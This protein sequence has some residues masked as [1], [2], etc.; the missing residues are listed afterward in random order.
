[1]RRTA[2]LRTPA[3]DWFRPRAALL[4]PG[5][6]SLLLAG[7]GCGEEDG[8]AAE[9]ATEAADSADVRPVVATAAIVPGSLTDVLE[10]SGRL[11]PRAEVMISSE[12]GG[13]VEEVRFDKGDRVVTGALLARVG[14]DLLRSALAEAEAELEGAQLDYTQA[15]LLVE[16]EASPRQ[17]FLGAEVNVKRFEARV[18][19]ARLRLARSEIAAPAAGVIVQRDIEPGEVLGPGSPVA[20][21]HDTSVLRATIGIP[22]TDIAFFSVGSPAE[23]AMDAYPDRSFEGRISYIAPSATRPGRNFQAEVEVANPD[24]VLRSGLIV[25]T[26]LQRRVFEDAVVVA[27][28]VLVERDGILHAFV[29]EDGTADL[30]AVTIG[31]DEG[32][33]VVITD[34]LAIGE[35]LI[36]DG[37]RNLLDGQP[38]RVVTKPDR[39]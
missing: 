24:G 15:R 10:I 9:T 14:S 13:A 5:A 36:T 28:D 31:P 17:D 8:Y 2:N 18:E 32:D 6:V 38:V 37:H 26:R 4:L 22:E 20:V 25:R 1:M 23:I 16:R 12:L 19:A 33:Q 21:L 34:G 30:R 3:G 27:R 39:D 35:T 29:L 11:E 7:A